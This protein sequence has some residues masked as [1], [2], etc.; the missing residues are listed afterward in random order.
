[1]GAVGASVVVVDTLFR[2]PSFAGWPFC[3]VDVVGEV[4]FP[5]HNL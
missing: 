4:L 3:S 5:F 1:L 2:H